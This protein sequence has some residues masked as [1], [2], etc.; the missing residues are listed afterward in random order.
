MIKTYYFKFIAALVGMTAAIIALASAQSSWAQERTP[1]AQERI[2]V[3]DSRAVAVAYAGS[4]FQVKKMKELTAQLKTAREAGDTNRISR[5]ETA[6]REWQSN[7]HRQGFGTA[8]VDD[9]LAEIASDLPTIQQAAGVTSL[10]SK[11]SETELRRRPNAVRIDV[12]MRLVD[13]FQPNETQRKRAIE[14]QKIKPQKIR[15]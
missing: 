4:T 1:P 9:I 15:E 11:W 8:P 2:G 13:A 7:L 12:T 14:I 6:G 3:Y 10:V 5:L